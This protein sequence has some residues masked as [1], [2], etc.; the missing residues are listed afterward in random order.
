MLKVQVLGG[1]SACL[2]DQPI[3]IALTNAQQLLAYLLFTAGNT[4]PREQLGEMLWGDLARKDQLAQLRQVIHQLKVA[5]RNQPYIVRRETNVVFNAALPYRFDA[6]ELQMCATTNLQNMSMERLLAIAENYQPLLPQF[7]TAWVIEQRNRLEDIYDT[8]LLP[9]LLE[10]LINSQKWN[11]V[12]DWGKLALSRGANRGVEPLYC[13]VMKAYYELG[14]LRGVSDTYSQLQQALD[15]IGLDISRTASDLY[16]RLLREDE[17]RFS[18]HTHGSVSTEV[19]PATGT[20]PP[21]HLPDYLLNPPTPLI[22]RNDL[23][24]RVVQDIRNDQR[25]L[26]TLL[27][28]GGIG[29]TRL[30]AAAALAT[31]ERFPD[32]VYFVALDAIRSEENFYATLA[33]ELRFTPY[34]QTSLKSQVLNY[35]REKRLLL[36]VDNFETLFEQGIDGAAIIDE[37]CAKAPLLKVLVTTRQGLQ[38][39]RERIFDVDGLD[40]PESVDTPEA[41]TYGA[42][43]LFDEIATRVNDKFSLARD[44]HTVIDICKLLGGTPLAIEIA[45]ALVRGMNCADIKARIAENIDVL[46]S[47]WSNTSPRQRSLRAV[48]EYSFNLLSNDEQQ[49]YARLSVFADGFTQDAATHVAQA[50]FSSLRALKD[51]ALIRQDAATRYYMHSF[52]Q[53]FGREKLHEMNLVD[54]AQAAMAGYFAD[55]ARTHTHTLAQLQLEWTNLLAGMRMAYEAQNWMTTMGYADAL[56]EP[57]YLQAR[58]GDI[59]QGMQWACE[60]A[61][62]LNDERAEA[63][64]LSHWGRA[65]VRQG[66][67]V[68]ADRLFERGLKQAWKLIDSPSIARILN[69]RAQLLIE[70]AE[71]KQAQTLLD[72]C[73]EIYEELN[74]LEKQVD[75]IRQKARVQYNAEDDLGAKQ[76]VLRAQELCPKNGNGNFLLPLFR[77]RADIESRLG[78]YSEAVAYQQKTSSLLLQHPNNRENAALY[79]SMAITAWHKKE[80]AQALQH[81]QT[82]CRLFRQMGDRKST[83]YVFVLQGYVNIDQGNPTSAVQNLTLATTWLKELNDL[84]ALVRPLQRLSENYRLLKKVDQANDLLKEAAKMAALT[85]HPLAPSLNQQLKDFGLL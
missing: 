49:T 78:N 65:C 21:I 12:V 38:L 81:A 44:L 62:A 5:C 34:S 17:P 82:S 22:G 61:I 76:L 28:I 18:H 83:A 41:S 66:D 35:L 58:Y 7:D 11:L 63:R 39:L 80:F 73:L 52:V 50:R 20:H 51:C 10:K 16:G 31:A 47:R 74:D 4:V 25:Q 36:I 8:K 75:C 60:A 29:K 72:E 19:I 9:A 85:S 57:W 40:T 2:D 23:L 54:T 84:S 32:G 53:Q 46:L 45:A 77:L 30:A 68:E 27:G 33:E 67:Y 3:R 69:E 37:A 70:R 13:Q 24:Q 48:L 55:Y 43:A 14:N 1:F 15:E 26:I 42:I 64:F 56:C 6:A 71:W 79:Y 59:R